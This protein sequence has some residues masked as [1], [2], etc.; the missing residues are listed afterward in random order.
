MSNVILTLPSLR[1]E[2]SD[3]SEGQVQGVKQESLEPRVS[4]SKVYLSI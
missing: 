4:T 1:Q 2:L 3:C